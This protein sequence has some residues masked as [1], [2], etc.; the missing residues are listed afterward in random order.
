MERTCGNCQYCYSNETM[1]D[2]YICTNGNSVMLGEFVDIYT[3]AECASC[4]TGEDIDFT[5]TP[6]YFGEY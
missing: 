4:E 3:D 1:G 2:L 5:P 6:N